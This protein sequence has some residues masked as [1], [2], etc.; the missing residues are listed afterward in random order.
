MAHQVKGETSH[1][2]PPESDDIVDRFNTSTSL[3]SMLYKSKQA[4][5]VLKQLTCSCLPCNI[6]IKSKAAI[7]ILVWSVVIGAIYLALLSGFGALGF[8]LQHQEHGTQ[9]FVIPVYT[10][11]AAYAFLPRAHAQGVM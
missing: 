10:V 4:L 2:L 5:S 9:K 6:C 7:L 8:I 1:L 11:V 3:P